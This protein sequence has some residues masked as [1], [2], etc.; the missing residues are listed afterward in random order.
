[1]K[2]GEPGRRQ[3]EVEGLAEILKECYNNNVLPSE[4]GV[5]WAR[6]GGIVDLRGYEHF[7]RRESFDDR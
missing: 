3:L 5:T 7:P 6:K 2:R 1:M 4:L